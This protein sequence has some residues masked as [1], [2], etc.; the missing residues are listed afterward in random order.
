MISGLRKFSTSLIF[1]GCLISISFTDRS[2]AQSTTRMIDNTPKRPSICL[3]HKNLKGMSNGYGK[4]LNT[5]NINGETALVVADINYTSNI[6]TFARSLSGKENK[7]PVYFSIWSVDEILFQTENL[8]HSMDRVFI[9]INDREFPLKYSY[10]G[11]NSACRYGN[12]SVSWSHLTYGYELSEDIKETLRINSSKS[13]VKIVYHSES[14]N[15]T[16]VTEFDI[17]DGTIQTWRKID[18]FYRRMAEK[19]KPVE[20]P[21]V[22][23]TESNT[24]TSIDSEE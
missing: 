4:V 20:T 23:T 7:D 19:N 22:E 11:V 5:T 16:Y 14:G 1:F 24:S 6:L 10:N 8:P 18:K 17:G 15:R 12:E 21:A 13:N 9:K 3:L 2:I